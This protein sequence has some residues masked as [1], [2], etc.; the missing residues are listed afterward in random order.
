MSTPTGDRSKGG[1][2]SW[3]LLTVHVDQARLVAGYGTESIDDGTTSVGFFKVPNAWGANWGEHGHLRL[4]GGLNRE[5]GTR[6][7]ARRRCNANNDPAHSKADDPPRACRSTTIDV[8]NAA[9]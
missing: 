7:L 4:Q 1:I 2:I 9:T 3:C 6:K 8:E 5:A